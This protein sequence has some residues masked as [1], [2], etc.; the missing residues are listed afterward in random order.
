MKNSILFTPIFL[1]LFG[2][3]NS[4]FATDT[5]WHASDAS[6][7]V[8]GTPSALTTTNITETSATFN[9]SE[10]PGAISYSVQIRW[11]NGTWT[12]LPGSPFDDTSVMVNGLTPGTTYEW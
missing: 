7:V 4:S 10:V 9:W 11:P 12:F 5:R 1:L 2:L 6:A 8:C 3:L